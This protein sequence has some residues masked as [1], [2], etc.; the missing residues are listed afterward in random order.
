MPE[1]SADGDGCIRRRCLDCGRHFASGLEQQDGYWCPY[2]GAQRSWECWFTP[3]QQRYLDDALAEDALAIADLGLE[4]PYHPPPRAPLNESTA[5][6]AT[7][8]VACHPG[9]PLKLEPGWSKAAWCHL[10]GAQPQVGRT[11]LGRVRLRRRE[12]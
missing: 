2:C 12:S 10:C 11:A 9:A 5:D 7:V 1:I 3:L 4:D 8:A 6:L